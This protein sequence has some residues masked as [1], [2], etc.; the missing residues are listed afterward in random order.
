MDKVRIG[1]V[2]A[3]FAADFHVESL[4]K[5][6]GI[7]VELAAVTSLRPKSREAFG[8]KY[9][10]PVYESVKAMLGHIVS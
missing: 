9:N 1:I 10:I 3:G 8:R 7:D 2:G 5:V 6:Y 4:K